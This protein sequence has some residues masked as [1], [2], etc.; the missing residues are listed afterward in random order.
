M[1]EYSYFVF[2]RDIYSTDPKNP[3]QDD[4]NVESITSQV[5]AYNFKSTK[6]YAHAKLFDLGINLSLSS[7][8][9]KSNQSAY[10]YETYSMAEEESKYDNTIGFFLSNVSPDNSSLLQRGLIPEKFYNKRFG[11]IVIA[12]SLD[13]KLPFQIPA[14]FLPKLSG[15]KRNTRKYRTRSKS[16]RRA[17]RKGKGKGNRRA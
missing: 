10:S 13:G 14:E 3:T 17:S 11:S 4:K 5:D 1:A 9:E 2:L 16:K 8:F 12:C 15:G 6:E 7:V